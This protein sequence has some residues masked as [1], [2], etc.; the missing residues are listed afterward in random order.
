MSD[1]ILTV[2]QAATSYDLTTLATVKEE[3][4]ISVGNWDNLLGRYISEVSDRIASYC[5]RVFAQETVSELFIPDRSIASGWGAARGEAWDSAWEARILWR[6]RNNLELSR[7]PVAS[8]VSVVEDSDPAIDSSLYEFDPPTG[9]LYRLNGGAR[10]KW[11]ANRTLV[12]YTGGY[13]LLNGLPRSIEEAAILMVKSKWF[14]R[15]RDPLLKSEDVPGVL[16][17]EFWVGS[18]SAGDMSDDVTAILSPYRR[19][20]IQ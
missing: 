7:T 6:A 1:T 10:T 14:A 12:T 5:N 2:T 19:T 16:K 17:Q 4:N 15:S 11:T 9:F 18:P 3:L 13:V 20:I 8:I